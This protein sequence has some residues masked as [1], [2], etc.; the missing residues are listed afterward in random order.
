VLCISE[1]KWLA[2]GST[3]EIT[4]HEKQEKSATNEK[5][6]MINY[7]KINRNIARWQL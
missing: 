5:H 2:T 4:A 1:N 7:V 6:S 3:A